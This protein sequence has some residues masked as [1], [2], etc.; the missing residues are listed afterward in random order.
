M[1][2]DDLQDKACD[3]HDGVEGLERAEEAGDAHEQ[4]DV[5]DAK[6]GYC[7][8]RDAQVTVHRA[9]QERAQG[10]AERVSGCKGVSASPKPSNLSMGMEENCQDRVWAWGA[11][12]MP[13]QCL[14]GA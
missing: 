8:V 3:V 2:E 5:L 11:L 6:A 10:Q 7:G 13:A 12:H 9:G 4:G 1:I 14:M